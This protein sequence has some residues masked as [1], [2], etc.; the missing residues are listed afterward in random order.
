MLRSKS[1]LV[2][3]L[4]TAALIAGALLNAKVGGGI[5]LSW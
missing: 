4:V 3:L 5:N 2:S 1:H